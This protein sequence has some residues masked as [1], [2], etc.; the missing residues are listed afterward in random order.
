MGEEAF[1]RIGGSYWE[2]GG[3]K[4]DRKHLMGD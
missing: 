3:I 1:T 4:W 2:T